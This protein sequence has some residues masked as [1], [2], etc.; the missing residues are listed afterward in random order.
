MSEIADAFAVREV[1]EGVAAEEAANRMTDKEI[2]AG[3]LICS[4]WSPPW[5]QRRLRHMPRLIRSSTVSF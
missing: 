2:A 1:I 5:M 4:L 3:W